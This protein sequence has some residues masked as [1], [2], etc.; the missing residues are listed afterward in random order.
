M[1]GVLFMS[2]NNQMLSSARLFH[3]HEGLFVCP[4]CREILTTVDGKSLACRNQHSFDLAKSGYT[5]LLLHPH[6]GKRGNRGNYD[7]QMFES[8]RLMNRAALF[9]PLVTMIVAAVRSRMVTAA[10]S[11]RLLDAG[12][13]EGSLLAAADHSVD[14]ALNLLSPSNY[15]ELCRVM[16]S[17]GLLVKAV[18]EAN[19]LI[20][21]REQL[22][23]KVKEAAY[24][25]AGVVDLFQEHMTS[26]DELQWK[27]FG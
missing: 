19:H 3:E 26:V 9:A 15:R 16:R 14:I 2:K 25:N 20:Q 10:N 6:T 23:S 8:R 22:Y 5:N 13:S 18:P 24:S 12:C 4:I 21:L 7:R 11:I 17:D 27:Y 1:N